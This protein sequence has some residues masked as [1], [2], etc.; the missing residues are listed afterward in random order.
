MLSFFLFF[1]RHYTK[2][3]LCPFNRSATKTNCLLFTH[4]F[5]GF[6]RVEAACAS[7]TSSTGARDFSRECWQ[8]LNRR[9]FCFCK[10][11]SQTTR[12]SLHELT[13]FRRDTSSCHTSSC[14]TG[15]TRTVVL[16]QPEVYVAAMVR[17]LVCILR[18]SGEGVWLITTRPRSIEHAQ[19]HT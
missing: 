10:L 13:A 9:T 1:F 14:H 11:I 16:I 4:T 3:F 2:V 19:P 17:K 5:N 15:R 8:R 6:K 18:T 7:T 12:L